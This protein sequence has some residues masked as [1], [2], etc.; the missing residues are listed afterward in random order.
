MCGDKKVILHLVFDGILFDRLYQRFEGMSKYENIYLYGIV[1]E[2][3]KYQY[4]NCSEKIMHANTIGE[5]GE[6]ISDPQV[7]VIF[8]HG[9][10][11]DFVKAISYIGKDVTV[12]WMCY[13]ME[14]YE[15]CL[16]WPSL[17]SL[18]IYKPKTHLF[19]LKT[20]HGYHRVSAEL[21][22]SFPFIYMVLV[23]IGDFFKGKFNH[24]LK[25]MLARI[26]FV[27][28]PLNREYIELKKKHPY[29]KAKPFVLRGPVVKEEILIHKTIGGILF[30]H[31][32]TISNNHLDIIAAIKN[33]KIDL[34]DRNVYVP[35][36]YGSNMLSDKVRKESSFEGANVNFLMNALPLG[37]YK[38]M[39]SLCSHAIFGMMRQSGLGNICLCFQKGIKV[40]LFK[41]SILYQ[42]FKSDGYYVYSIE[43][44]LNNNNI[45]EPLSSEQA[46]HNYN[47]FYTH[48]DG[49]E[50]TYEQQ[51][52]KILKNI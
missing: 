28:T 42:Q 5:W 45:N 20:M 19:W 36:S 9:L 47:V 35:L 2:K 1:G 11:L 39:M 14:I 51:F 10:W 16:H 15:N 40:F 23:R 26:D 17:M 25:Q 6:I 52:D 50:G 49:S 7:D 31:S 34:R 44:D 3:K 43:E 33:K 21:A 8:L 32:A 24:E 29:I 38:K 48:F 12:M 18:K 13:G 37:E 22:Y 41:D 30:E 27:F 4:I 46:I